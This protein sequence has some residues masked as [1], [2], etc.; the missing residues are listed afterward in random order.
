MVG[1]EDTMNTMNNLTT[2]KSKQKEVSKM[3]GK[4][5][6]IMVVAIALSWRRRCAGRYLSHKA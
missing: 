4:I 2:F 5:I 3:K 6:I 1:G